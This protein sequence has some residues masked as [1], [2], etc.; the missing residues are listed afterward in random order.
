MKSRFILILL[1]LLYSAVSA[2]A[3]DILENTLCAEC[4]MKVDPNSRFSA[5]VIDRE[6]NRRYFFCDIGDMLYH[7]RRSPERIKEA[8]VRDFIS[9]I[10]IDGLSAYYVKNKEFKTPMSWQIGA[11]KNRTE[12]E[13]FGKVYTF[14]DAFELIR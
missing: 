9:G 6:D 12:A 13:R 8:Y 14:R 5:S 10:W 7:Y 11:F 1:L 3:Q 4:G 2:L